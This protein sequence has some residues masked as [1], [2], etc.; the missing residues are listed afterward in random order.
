MSNTSSPKDQLNQ[1]LL[2][3]NGLVKKLPTMLPCGTKEGPL[4]KY[5]TDLDYNKDNPYE[6]FNIA[7]E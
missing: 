7:W 2:K 1:L 5:H 3:L 6:S 4:A